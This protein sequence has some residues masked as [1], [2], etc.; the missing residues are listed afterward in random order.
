MR[1]FKTTGEYPF[2]TTASSQYYPYPADL[3]SIEGMFITV[4]SVNFPLRI[5]NSRMD[6]EQLNAILIQ[7]SALPQ[8]YF[9]R[10]DDF[11]VWPI[12][13]ATYTGNISYRYYDRPLSVADYTNGTV[14]MTINSTTVTGTNTT[15]TPAMVGRQITITDPTIYGQ[16]YWY[17]I[18]GY[19]S[20]TQITISRA[21]V[22]ATTASVAFKVGEVPNIPP[23]GQICLINGVT[24][25]FYSGMR[26]DLKNATGYENMFWTG[27]PNNPSKVEGD[28]NIGGGLIG[29]VNRYQSRDESHIIKRQNKL[30]P[31]NFKIFATRLS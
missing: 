30:N 2:S 3:Q 22:N 23:E 20:A 4:G 11:G 9:P 6:W 25:D 27:D 16:G 29:L 10:R 17:R 14:V 8:F 21:W 15:F 1:N 26:K 28:R 31:L 5:I 24:A 12:P 13:Q 19:T 7:A 18:S